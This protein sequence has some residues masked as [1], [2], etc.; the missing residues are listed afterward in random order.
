MK[1]MCFVVFLYGKQ[2]QWYIPLYIYSINKSYPGYDI[3]IYINEDL[4]YDLKCLL[5]NASFLKNYTIIDNV[6]EN[7]K[8]QVPHI[9]PTSKN[10]ELFNIS[11]QSARWILYD[12]AFEDYNAIYIG[13]IDIFISKENYDLYDQHMKHCNFMKIPFSNMPRRWE[14]R[15]LCNFKKNF[16]DLKKFGIYELLRKLRDKNR[17]IHRLSGLH[18]VVVKEYYP[19]VMPF[20]KTYQKELEDITKTRST[21][22]CKCV[23]N[24]E[25]VLFDLIKEAGFPVAE[26]DYHTA[27]KESPS[28]CPD[29]ALIINYR[30]HHG[31]HL[32]IWRSKGAEERYPSV[33][34]SKAYKDY[35]KQFSRLRENDP[36]F[37]FLLQNES[38]FVKTVIQNMDEC[39][40]K[41]L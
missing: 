16:S 34:K 8:Y 10:K 28:V 6:R 15:Q 26:M 21:K 3:R 12:S 31:L 2:Y 23:F 37:R 35:Y 19:K 27:G 18:F 13:D 40:R 4:S 17:Y 14:K 38:V 7:N 29:D 22:W 20:F 32:G 41:V 36:N 30:P 11:L 39:M 1:K 33:I 25:V 9:V 24:D 5:Q